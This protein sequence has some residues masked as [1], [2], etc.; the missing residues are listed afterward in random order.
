MSFPPLPA[1]LTYDAVHARLREVH[2]D[3]RA[4]HTRVLGVL[5]P[6]EETDVRLMVE[7]DG[8]WCIAHGDVSYD[9]RIAAWC[10]ASSIGRDDTD[11]D[12]LHT[13]INLVDQV[14][15]EVEL[16][17]NET[18]DETHDETPDPEVARD[19]RRRCAECGTLVADHGYGCEPVPSDCPTRLD[20]GTTKP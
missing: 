11:D 12:L 16:F 7:H 1:S 14:E 18:H 9:Q 6:V 13:A 20:S 10:G 3:L 19:E 15:S 2:K 17:F 5:V 8:S 4:T